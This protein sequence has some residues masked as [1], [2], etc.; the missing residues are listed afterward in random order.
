VQ[1]FNWR[2]CTRG[3]ALGYHATSYAAVSCAKDVLAD[4]WEEGDGRKFVFGTFA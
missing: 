1:A 4:L 3:A 2:F